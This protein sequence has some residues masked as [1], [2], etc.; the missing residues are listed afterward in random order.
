MLQLSY[1]DWYALDGRK[2]YETVV[3]RNLPLVVMEPVRGGGLARCHPDIM[4]VFAGANPDVSAASWALRWAGSLPGA[5]V[6]LSGMSTMDHVTENIG[7]FSPLRP[8]TDAETKVI[9]EA[10]DTFKKL[11]LVPCTECNYC[12]KCPRD[13]PIARLF[14]GKNDTVRFGYS[15]YLNNY[16]N[17]T[18]P[19]NQMTACTAC[20]VCEDICPQNIDIIE[21]LK[22]LNAELV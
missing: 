8:V 7:L 6:V 21:R 14:G 1:Y 12:D 3:E 22:A 18:K 17:W 9:E 5:D 16:K 13:I 19:E 11:P 15:W 10:M 2:L 4:K 20:G